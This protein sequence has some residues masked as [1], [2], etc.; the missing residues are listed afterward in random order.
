[1][2]TA[3]LALLATML[4]VGMA[5]ASLAQ[6]IDHTGI[7]INQTSDDPAPGDKATVEGDIGASTDACNADHIVRVQRQADEYSNFHTFK[8]VY[9]DGDGHY[10]ATFAVPR[11]QR[12][13]AVAPWKSGC[14]KSES[15]LITI[16]T[17]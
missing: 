17:Q 10:T 3:L 11:T 4:V 2:K 14:G 6:H 13:R 9:S 5:S 1:M 8:K 7:T 16:H 12:Y 15:R